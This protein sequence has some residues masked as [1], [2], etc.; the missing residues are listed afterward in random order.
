MSNLQVGHFK[1]NG[2]WFKIL[3]VKNTNVAVAR[4]TVF[5]DLEM[6]V[7]Y[8]DFGNAEPVLRDLT[9]EKDMNVELEINIEDETHTFKGEAV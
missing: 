6:K 8:G 2:W 3:E 4:P 7:N 5:G 1:V 9:G